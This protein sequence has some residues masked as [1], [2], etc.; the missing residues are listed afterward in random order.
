VLGRI[1]GA[2]GGDRP[3][4]SPDGRFVA[5]GLSGRGMWIADLA[6]GVASP[7]TSGAATASNPT[8]IPGSSQLIYNRAGFRDGKDVMFVNSVGGGVEKELPEARLGH[9]HPSSVSADGRYLVYAGGVDGSD[10]WVYP[11][12]GAEKPHAY[13]ETSTIETQPTLSPDGRRIAYTSNVSGRVEVYVE[14]FAAHTRRV[15]ASLSGGTSPHWRGDGKELFYMA[16][17]GRIMVVAVQRIE[18]LQLGAASPLFQVSHATTLLSTAN[19]DVSADGQR[20][21]VRENVKRPDPSLFVVVNWS[22]LF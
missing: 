16:P 6:R 2:T 17:D 21:I 14:D 5:F 7:F 20:F 8:W 13:F 19:Y 15:Q 11:L 3:A 9:A 10:I 4:L 12:K 18:P 1:E 22:R